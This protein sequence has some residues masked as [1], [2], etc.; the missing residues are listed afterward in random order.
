MPSSRLHSLGKISGKT[1]QWLY[2]AVQ[3]AVGVGKAETAQLNS[4][5][6]PSFMEGIVD[7]HQPLYT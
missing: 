5:V 1:C 2:A 7:I 6:N 4:S 3:T